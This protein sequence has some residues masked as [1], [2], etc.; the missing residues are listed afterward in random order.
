MQE[1]KEERGWTS[2]WSY[3]TEGRAFALHMVYPGSISGILM[4]PW[5]TG[6]IPNA[7]IEVI[8]EHARS[9]HICPPTPKKKRSCASF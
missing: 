5:E 3:S 6:E 1:N 9:L 8:P 4:V 7:E 2:G